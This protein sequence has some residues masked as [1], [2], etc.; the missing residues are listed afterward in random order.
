[1]RTG[2]LAEIP[3][4]PIVIH[5]DQVRAVKDVEELKPDLKGNSLG[6]FCVL[7]KIDIC[8]SIVWL[9]ELTDLLI[10]LGTEGWY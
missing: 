7:I 8:R 9:T 3:I 5:V 10:T 4:R 2:G 1:M 6:D